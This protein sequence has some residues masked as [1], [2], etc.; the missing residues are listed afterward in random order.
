MCDTDHSRPTRSRRE[1]I[2]SVGAALLACG[3]CSYL[4]AQ[5]ASSSDRRARYRRMNLSDQGAERSLE[6]YER[7][8]TAMLALPPSDPR[9]WYRHALI[10]T[11][12]CPHG[13]WWFLP[14]HRAYTGWLERICR[15]LSGDPEFALP[16]WDWTESPKLPERFLLGNLNPANFKITGF[17][18]FKSQFKASVQDFW[19]ALSSAQLRQLTLR[20]YPA[21]ALLWANIQNDP[22]GQ[23]DE[24]SMF[25]D[26]SFVRLVNPPRTPWLD[27]LASKAVALS[28]I[29]DALGPTNFEDFGS[30]KASYHSGSAAQGVL[31][32]QPHNLVHNEVGGIVTGPPDRQGFMRDF[33]SPVDPIFFMHHSNIDR[34]W[35]VWT[36]KQLLTGQ[37]QG[38][39]E[40]YPVVPVIPSDLSAWM[41]EPFLF[42]I[43]PDGKPVA[44]QTSGDYV[45]TGLFDYDYQPGSGEIV[46]PKAAPQLNTLAG[47][48]ITATMLPQVASAPNQASGTVKVPRAALPQPVPQ[49]A[50]TRIMARITTELPPDSRGIRLHVLV[51]APVGARNV[52]FSDAYYAG[53]FELFGGHRLGGQRHD[54]QVTFT[55]GLTGSVERLSAERRFSAD[56]MR[57]TVVAD[58]PGVSL[59][60]PII[61][62]PQITV[63]TS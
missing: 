60:T 41:S 21:D 42:F 46:V 2:A 55:I 38:H 48:T 24:A 5:A 34:L 29:L 54:S 20:D 58:W 44:Q 53:S 23:P 16:Y 7:A 49:Q 26:I 10:H 19:A 25:S 47:R 30:H 28:T 43:G 32:S 56:S 9:N 37:Q 1:F 18:D 52:N 13:N 15:D 33:L 62:V 45:S 51:N 6:S 50:G 22:P 31:E 17:A 12:D 61:R 36:R 3:N 14:W 40:K 8:V 63:I 39:P 59:K 4:S 35:D 27:A 57:L 11:M